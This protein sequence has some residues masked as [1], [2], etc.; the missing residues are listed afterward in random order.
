MLSIQFPVAIEVL[1][2]DV[3]RR[4]RTDLGVGGRCATISDTSSHFATLLAWS[5]WQVTPTLKKPWW[6]EAIICS[7]GS[8]TKTVIRNQ[9]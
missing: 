1:D 5:K 6:H 4:G 9:F 7:R 3:F 2:T 8:K